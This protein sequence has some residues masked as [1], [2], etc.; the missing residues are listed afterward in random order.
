MTT[1][2]PAT[3]DE[4]PAA[5]V[6]AQPPIAVERPLSVALLPLALASFVILAFVMAAWTFVATAL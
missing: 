6:E 3:Q 2:L 1:N 5:Q 4:A